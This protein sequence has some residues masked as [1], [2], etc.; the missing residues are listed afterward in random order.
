MYPLCTLP[1]HGTSILNRA[2]NVGY[3][4]PVT[5]TSSTPALKPVQLGTESVTVGTF[6]ESPQKRVRRKKSGLFGLSLPRQFPWPFW[7]RH[8]VVL[9]EGHSHL[10]ARHPVVDPLHRTNWEPSTICSST[11]RLSSLDDA[12]V[13]EG[14]SHLAAASCSLLVYAKAWNKCWKLI[15][16][17]NLLSL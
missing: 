6:G 3:L 10:K 15:P 12:G 14:C 17:V 16:R 5:H 4:S 2:G 1:V 9:D 7:L 11:T 8:Q 13:G